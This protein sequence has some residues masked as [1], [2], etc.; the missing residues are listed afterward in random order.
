M[1]KPLIFETCLHTYFNIGDVNT[2]SVSGLKGVEYIDK[3]AGFK[4][5]REAN[6]A[7]RI[8]AETDRVYLNHTGATAIHDPTLHRT[9]Q[10]EKSGSVSTVVW[11][12]W[13]NKS[14]AMPDFGD[15]EY[16]QMI[17]V[18]SGNVNENKLTLAPGAKSVLKVVLSSQPG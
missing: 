15:E 9:I 11:N 13:I 6:E 8:N 10:V 7:V 18:E 16:N 2:V 4:R 1:F 17:C 3:A 12:P 5:V 14:Q